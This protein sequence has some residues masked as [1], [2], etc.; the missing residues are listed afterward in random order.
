MEQ[1]RLAS[2][3]WVHP[4]GP[5][6]SAVVDFRRSLPPRT[7]GAHEH[8]A[9]AFEA[10]KSRLDL[11]Q[12]LHSALPRGALQDRLAG[13]L[14]VAGRLG[15]GID[16]ERVAPTNGTQSA[17]L[18][19]LPYIVGRGGRLLAERLS[20]GALRN[21]ADSAGVELVGV[22]IDEEGVL[23]DAFER[24]CVEASPGAL[25]CNPTV[26]NPTTA[27]MSEP[28]RLAIAEIARRH[29]VPI[30]EDDTLGRL[31]PGAAAPIA[32]LAPDVTWY[33]MS[34]SKALSHGLRIAYLVAPTPEAREAVLSRA[35]QLSSWT[36]A[37]LL[38]ALVAEWVMSG[39][40]DAISA[41]IRA[42]N[43]GR[44]SF[45]RSRLGPYG[46]RSEPGSMHVWLPLP[47]GL[48]GPRF[49]EMA[50]AQGVLLRPAEVFAVDDQPVP[51]AVRLSLS[52]P[53]TRAQA[54]NGILAV[55]DLVARL[56]R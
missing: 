11:G 54:E 16:I 7:T 43:L 39:A 8:L 6:A 9:E 12:L 51:A 49:A 41:E 52:T 56:H 26:Q 20:Y 27:V 55:R 45:A 48:T 40:A 31:H 46:V 42:E 15:P 3:E 22:D 13:T 17:L 34:T 30:I 19:I 5:E 50:A 23:P 53:A 2:S 36:A 10:L 25:Y 18:L 32:R 24:A 38:S 29:G 47:R 14:F 35:P 44:E 33:V 28:R 4:R 21:V 37:P 1:A